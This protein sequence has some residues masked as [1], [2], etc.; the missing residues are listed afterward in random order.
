MET[1]Y[2]CQIVCNIFK[3][4]YFT[5]LIEQVSYF[6]WTKHKYINFSV[7]C[8]VQIFLLPTESM[9]FMQ[10]MQEGF[11][12]KKPS[13]VTLCRAAA[14]LLAAVLSMGWSISWGSPH[15]PFMRG[16]WKKNVLFTIDSLIKI[17]WVDIYVDV[18]ACNHISATASLTSLL[19]LSQRY[20]GLQLTLWGRS[21]FLFSVSRW[22]DCSVAG[23]FLLGGDF[24]M[25]QF[26]KRHL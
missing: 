25:V 7:I 26:G 13:L 1:C 3:Y 18:I 10:E 2:K 24:Q 8:K 4:P 14:L 23:E 15:A 12:G 11:G 19:S 5:Q 21:C 6:F 9:G 17:I 16:F 22:P 20:Q